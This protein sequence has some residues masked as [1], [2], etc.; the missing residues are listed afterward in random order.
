MPPQAV[1]PNAT[2]S[3]A[4]PRQHRHL[5]VEHRS[6]R[7]FTSMLIRRFIAVVPLQQ[8]TGRPVLVNIPN[9]K[10]LEDVGRAGHLA[11]FWMPLRLRPTPNRARIARKRHHWSSS[12]PAQILAT[13]DQSHPADNC[14]KGRTPGAEIANRC[15]GQT[16]ICRRLDEAYAALIPRK[17]GRQRSSHRLRRSG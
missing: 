16:V 7:S 12:M 4:C 13:P 11:D 1:K 5:D 6:G 15:G 8:E 17:H 2:S 3:A 9:K 14:C 10:Q